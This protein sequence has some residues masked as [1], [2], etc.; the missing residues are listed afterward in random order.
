MDGLIFAWDALKK[1]KK[2]G[3]VPKMRDTNERIFWAIAANAS[4][5]YHTLGIVL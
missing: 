3:N 5:P 1:G 2:R 4:F